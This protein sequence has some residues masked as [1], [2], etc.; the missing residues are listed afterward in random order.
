VVQQSAQTSSQNFR[1]PFLYVRAQLGLLMLQAPKMLDK[2]NFIV[3]NLHSSDSISRVAHVQGLLK[4]RE[5]KSTPAGHPRHAWWHS[6]SWWHA[7]KHLAGGL[8][9]MRLQ[10]AGSANNPTFWG[11]RTAYTTQYALFGVLPGSRTTSRLSAAPY[12]PTGAQA[13]QNP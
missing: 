12:C 3:T 1:R 5:I 10:L 13:H 11:V 4:S 8:L 9:Q 7:W 6:S 2:I